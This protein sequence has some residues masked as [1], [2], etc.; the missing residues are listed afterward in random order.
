MATVSFT[1]TLTQIFWDSPRIIRTMSLTGA[2]PLLKFFEV[3][4]PF[5]RDCYAANSARCHPQRVLELQ[6]SHAYERLAECGALGRVALRTSV[7]TG[8]VRAGLR[9]WSYSKRVP[10]GILRPPVYTYSAGGAY[11]PEPLLVLRGVLPRPLSTAR[12]HAAMRATVT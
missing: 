7:N 6:H 3:R 12:E 9:D 2:L 8:T 10:G 11:S 4:P 1:S 5:D